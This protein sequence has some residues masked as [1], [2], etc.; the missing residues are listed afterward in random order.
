MKTRNIV[1]VFGNTFSVKNVGK[2][3][4]FWIMVFGLILISPAIS[5]GPLAEYG[6]APDP[7]YPSLFA[8]QGPYHL[9]VTEERIGT[10]PVSTTTVETD[11][12]VPD[13]DFDDG[14]IRL[15]RTLVGGLPVNVG[16]VTVPIT[17]NG[18]ADNQIRYLNVVVDLNQDG[19]WQV[20]SLGG[21]TTQQEWI[22]RNLAIFTE[23][24]T[25]V[26]ISVPFV[27]LDTSVIPTD[28]IWTRATLT[29]EIIDLTIF[30]LAGWNG[31]GPVGGF[32]RGETEDHLVSVESHTF[33][34]VPPGRIP[35]P[36]P[37]S[38]GDGIVQPWRGEQ[39]EPPNT[40]VCNANCQ[41][42]PQPPPGF[43][44]DGIVQP[45]R[46]EQCDPPDGVTCDANCQNIPQPPDPIPVDGIEKEG[47]PDIT[48]GCNECGPTSAANSLY[49]LGKAYGFSDKLPG[50]PN[51]PRSLIDELKE[52]M[53]FDE[54]VADDDFIQ[55]KKDIAKQLGLP[56][57]THCQDD[58]EGQIPTV[59]FICSELEKCQDV[60]LGITFDGGGGHW[61]TVVG[62][63]KYSDGSVKLKIHD[64]DDD[65]IGDVYYWVEPRPQSGGYLS[66]INYKDKNGNNLP[67]KIDIVCAESPAPVG[68]ILIPV[69]K[70]ELLTPWIALAA[71]LISAAAVTLIFVKRMKKQ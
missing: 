71:V 50:S 58:G 5:A 45:W 21:R 14:V 27:L 10:S 40:P 3:L 34:P 55:G 68:G 18:T 54:G 26:N 9:I 62:C 59:D 37:G 65:L 2:S 22:V 41:L 64:P 31:T 57:E 60:E 47:V 28:Q 16:Y 25:S 7:T 6:D 17:I 33:F 61:V 4:V 39:C 44:G 23:P 19:N 48:Q 1:K 20:Y 38:C 70:L 12:L 51:N 32:L 35:N 15:R 53:K 36:P 11:A 67:N 69:N 43:C 66:L 49:F 46:G 52:K 8:S 24:G 29:T 30:G 63:T 42:I 56:I 13:G